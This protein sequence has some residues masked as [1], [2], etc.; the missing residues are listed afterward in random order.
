MRIGF[1]GAGKVGFTLGKYFSKHGKEI[2]GY[3]SRNT[4]SAEEA[5]EFTDSRAFDNMGELIENSDVLFLTVPD[6]S[7]T[8]VYR[9]VAQCP[10]RGKLICHCSG[11]LSARLAFPDIKET[12]AYGYSVHPLFAVSSKYSAYE[13]LADVFFA[14]E[15]DE[16]RI[17]DIEGLM[18][19]VWLRYQRIDGENKIGYHCAA[20]IASN[21]M[22][23]LIKESV[24]ILGRCGFSP[25]DAVSALGPLVRGNV[26]HVLEDGLEASLTGP[27]E[28][29]DIGTII[30]HLDSFDAGKD[31]KV[32]GA[33]EDE[34]VFTRE[35]EK[36]LY[37]LLSKK[38]LPVAQAKHPD[39]SY[40]EIK[41]L[42]NE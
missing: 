18:K 11:A 28:R 15:G 29:G 38:I 33:D 41:K 37:K 32:N 19:S 10:I 42:L 7:I 5:A 9:Q 17:G 6:G 3:Y 1:I 26:Q 27:L 4:V 20:A 23:G 36:Q 24:D 22:V 31:E 2:T 21:L 12:G 30:K 16:E 14:V 40:E 13:E 39:R 25:E 34:G 8:D 35:E